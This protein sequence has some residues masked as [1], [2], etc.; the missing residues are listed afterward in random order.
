MD[1]QCEAYL[2]VNEDST[3]E[4]RRCKKEA[5]LFIFDSYY[6]P[7]KLCGSHADSYQKVGFQ[8]RRDK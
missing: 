3:L 5:G 4:D 1:N 2:V 7:R 6:G 8:L